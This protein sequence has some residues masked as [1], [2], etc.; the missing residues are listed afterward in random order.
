MPDFDRALVMGHAVLAKNRPITRQQ[1]E[2]LLALAGCSKPETEI[3]L[4]SALEAPP[5]GASQA[6]A[7]T[8][9]ACAIAV[10]PSAKSDLIEL[11]NLPKEDRERCQEVIA[12]KVRDLPRFN[13]GHP[14]CVDELFEALRERLTQ[15]WPDS[16]QSCIDGAIVVGLVD[17]GDRWDLLPFAVVKCMRETA[18]ADLA[19]RRGYR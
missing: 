1:A 5:R 6:E 3:L 18:P 10:N 14:F 16:H 12:F 2:E 15:L 17:R 7:A 4:H 9:V 11:A 19:M 8:A 13:V